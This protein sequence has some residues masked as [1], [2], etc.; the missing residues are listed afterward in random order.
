MVT[1]SIGAPERH[2]ETAVGVSRSRMY[3]I[4][5]LHQGNKYVTPWEV[6]QEEIDEL[7]WSLRNPDRLYF[8]KLRGV[9]GTRIFFPPSVLQESVV[10]VEA[11]EDPV[12]HVFN[13]DEWF[14][15][16]CDIMRFDGSIDGSLEK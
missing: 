5:V 11:Q 3:K 4:T 9:G 12:S 13:D 7:Y 15:Q 2:D 16:M 10:L 8:L 14:S 1:L 6:S